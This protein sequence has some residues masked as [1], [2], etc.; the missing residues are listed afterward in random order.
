[1]GGGGSGPQV[2]GITLFAQPLSSL[3]QMADDS[4]TVLQGFQTLLPE[5]QGELMAGPATSRSTLSL[6]SRHTNDSTNTA[7]L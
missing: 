2:V 7:G 1:M 5:A 3:A 4:V 6:H